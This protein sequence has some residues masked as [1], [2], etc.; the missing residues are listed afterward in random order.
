MIKEELRFI[1]FKDF[2]KRSRIIKSAYMSLSLE[3][4]EM[5]EKQAEMYEN[6]T[7]EIDAEEQRVE[8]EEKWT[9]KYYLYS[10]SLISL[11]RLD[12]MWEYLNEPES[13]EYYVSRRKL[14]EEYLK[15][16]I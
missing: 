2:Y 13:S 9:Y 8:L 4:K 12:L 6:R 16:R 11:T 10:N 14:G 7:D 3:E 1:G 15:A 5:Y